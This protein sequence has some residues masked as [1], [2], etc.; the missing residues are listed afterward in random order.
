M[1]TRRETRGKPKLGSIPGVVSP[2]TWT[3]GLN[4]GDSVCLHL[5]VMAS[6]GSPMLQFTPMDDF[7]LLH[8][9]PT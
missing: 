5:L 1:V 9:V 4:D 2:V 7:F 8:D 3:I 6:G